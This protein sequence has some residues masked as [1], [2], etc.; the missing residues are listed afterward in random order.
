M[1]TS[2]IIH[3]SSKLVAEMLCIWRDCSKSSYLRG[4]INAKG[5]G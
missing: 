4:S 5:V 2:N 1:W 3:Q